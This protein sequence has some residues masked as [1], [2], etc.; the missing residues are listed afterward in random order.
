M[1]L[2]KEF[3]TGDALTRDMISIGMP[4]SGRG[5]R[6]ANIEDTLVA[7]SVEGINGRQGRVMSV[8]VD[9]ISVH[10]ERI[11]V[12]RLTKMILELRKNSRFKNV[13][14]FWSAIAQRYRSDS[15]FFRLAKLYQNRSYN[16]LSFFSK[17]ADEYDSTDFQISRNGEDPR[18]I[19][20][21]LR[22]P[23]KVLRERPG[24]IRSAP[25]LSQRHLPYRQR[26]IIGA[27]YRADLWAAML[28]N[29]EI[30]VADLARH[31]YCSYNSAASAVYDFEVLK[32]A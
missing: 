29:P 17:D 23:Q 11:N 24:D 20:T 13:A 12:D 10:H 25:K 2:P 15:R 3:K 9:W 31:G 22:V 27:T 6:D 18:F 16:Y 8:L 4:F 26:V 19:G 30:E 1:I 5:S 21:C 14:I 32:P 28:R 7:A